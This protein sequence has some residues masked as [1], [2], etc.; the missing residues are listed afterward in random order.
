MI[1]GGWTYVWA[2]YTV[3]LVAL[4]AAAIVVVLRLMHWAARVRELEK[5]DRP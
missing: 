5:G 3:A 4:A 2:A 1:E